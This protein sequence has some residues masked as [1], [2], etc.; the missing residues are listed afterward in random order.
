MTPTLENLI[1]IAEEYGIEHPL[2]LLRPLVAT[3]GVTAEECARLLIKH[4]QL[5]QQQERSEPHSGNLHH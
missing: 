1:A 4:R 5:H 3:S 2:L